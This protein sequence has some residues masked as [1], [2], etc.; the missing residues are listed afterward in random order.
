MSALERAA[1]L[2]RCLFMIIP[3]FRIVLQNAIRWKDSAEVLSLATTANSRQ[4]PANHVAGARDE[5][6][7]FEVVEMGA[8]V[9]A[10]AVI[11]GRGDIGGADGVG[12]GISRGPIGG[13]IDVA[14]AHAAAGEQD[15]VAEGPVIAARV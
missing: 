7:A 10:E 15:R 1:C 6:P 12:R 14:A 13:A 9:D 4:Q 8:R 11:D 5:R 3:P 2:F